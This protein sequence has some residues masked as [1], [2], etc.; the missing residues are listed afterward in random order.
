METILLYTIMKNK[1]YKFF[2][3]GKY[4][5]NIIGIRKDNIH[6][7]S[8]DDELHLIYRDEL[9]IVHKIYKVT[10]DPGFFYLEN[11]MRVSGTA[12][13]CPGQY[14]GAL[15]QRGIVKVYRD[16]NKDLVLDKDAE[17]IHEGYFGINIHRSNSSRESTNVDKWSA[18]C[19]VFSDPKSFS[20]FMDIVKK[21]S[22]IY[23][24]SFTYT[25]LK[26][27]DLRL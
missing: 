25:L 10:T 5:I 3:K 7:N 20:D 14:S 16:S 17:T 2:T 11:P 24:N 4:N 27:E 22:E 18:G 15:C 21:S 9:S 19:Q 12:I 8:F 23:G 6:T 13:L 1:G 26:E